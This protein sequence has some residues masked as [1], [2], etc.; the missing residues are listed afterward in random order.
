MTNTPSPDATS[1]KGTLAN[2]F[3][4]SIINVPPP[5]MPDSRAQSELAECFYNYA[6]EANLAS[7]KPVSWLLNKMWRKLFKIFSVNRSLKIKV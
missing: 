4:H 3:Y 2:R 1:V 7:R 6:Q 5:P